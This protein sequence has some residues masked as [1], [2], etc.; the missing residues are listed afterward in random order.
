MNKMDY[1]FTALLWY[2]QS[3]GVL[4]ISEFSEFYKENWVW[5]KRIVEGNIK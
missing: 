2:L 1:N 5:V 4:K 3:K